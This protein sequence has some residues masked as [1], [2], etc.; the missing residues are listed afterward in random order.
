MVLP[1]KP[2][3]G[4][5]NQLH[6][7]YIYNASAAIF[8][9]HIDASLEDC[10]FSKGFGIGWFTSWQYLRLYQDE[11]RLVTVRTHGDFIMGN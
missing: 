9:Q 1:G 7:G 5:E 10:L 6:I 8:F 11:K 4:F 2:Q 3:A